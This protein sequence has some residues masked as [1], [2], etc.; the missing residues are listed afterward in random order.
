MPA[1]RCCWV[2]ESAGSCG[3]EQGTNTAVAQMDRVTQ[4]NAANAEESASASEEL[5][6]QAEQMNEVVEQLASMVGGSNSTSTTRRTTR[7]S[8]SL[9]HSDQAFHQI[10]G[11]KSN[12][13]KTEAAKAIPLD[14]KFDDFNG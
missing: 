2:V 9:N 1:E 13:A 7:S 10:A 12:P 5:S 3:T 4:S 6:G 8:Q 14:D 11:G